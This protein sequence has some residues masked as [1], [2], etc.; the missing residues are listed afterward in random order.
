T[1]TITPTPAGATL[2]EGTALALN[3]AFSDPDNDPI[4]GY[5]IDWGDGSDIAYDGSS[6]NPSHVYRDGGL[7]NK[8]FVYDVTT[9]TSVYGTL[10]TLDVNVQIVPPTI[11]LSGNVQVVQNLPYTLTLGAVTEA[12]NEIVTSYTVNWGDGSSETFA[13][14]PVAGTQVTHT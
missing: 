11:A 6:L 2:P 10:G 5:R 1:L 13:G 8:A 7:P 14:M 9:A 12:G 4:T 3:L